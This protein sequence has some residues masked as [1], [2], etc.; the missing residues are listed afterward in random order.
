[1]AA[2]PVLGLE[3]LRITFPADGGD[4]RAV[5]DGVS[6]T[7][8][9]GERVGLVGE[10]GSGKS[11]T[12]LAALAMVPEPGVVAGRVRVA[13][14]DLGGAPPG[15]LRRLRGRV[16][17]WIPQEPAA[18]LDPTWRIGF[19][20]DE[21]VR[22][23]RGAGRRT[24]REITRRLL[25]EVGFERPDGIARSW[26]HQ[27]S[28]GEAQRV[29]LAMALAGEPRLLLADEPTTALDLLTQR[30]ILELLRATS[31]G[32]GTALVLVSHD[33]E[34][35]AATVERLAVLLAGR[36]V[37][38]GDAAALL[39][40]PLHPYTR[41]LVAASRRAVVAPA[42]DHAPQAP[43]A[44]TGCR[45]AP[46]CPHAEPACRLREPDL[47][48]AGDGRRLRCPVVPRRGHAPDGG[49]RA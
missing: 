6:L 21:L 34:V 5:V 13:G 44:S 28:G 17:G 31:A 29:T 9:E 26:P 3:Q 47:V 10:S 39:G 45:Y 33:L 19:Q 36:I 41:E 8:D 32:R 4:R 27:L 35:V 42:G 2:E 1:M 14:R 7:V 30:D 46:R 24:A 22:A 48:D 16:V 11:L 49:G 20:L 38:E 40:N 25:L 12:L 15:E 23:H 37:E 43:P 18:S